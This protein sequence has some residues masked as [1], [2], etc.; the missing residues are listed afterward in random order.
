MRPGGLRPTLA[1]MSDPPRGLCHSYSTDKS[2]FSPPQGTEMSKA[3]GC[4]V[5]GHIP[6]RGNAG[7]VS[8]L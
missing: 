1:G 8:P 7:A 4:R 5:R 2:L 6:I 3:T